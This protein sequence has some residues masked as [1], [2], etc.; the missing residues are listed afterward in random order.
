MARIID[1]AQVLF[2]ADLIRKGKK[3][4]E[5]MV[6][7]SKKWG[8]ISVNTFDRRLASA[9]SIVKREQDELRKETDKKLKEESDHLVNE[10]ISVL[11]RKVIL[12]KIAKGELEAYKCL[13]VRGELQRIKTTPDHTDIMKAIGELNKME[14]E[15]KNE[16]LNVPKS[17]VTTITLPD[18]SVISL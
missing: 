10:I 16:S 7:Y 18:G 9:K 3:R 5:M 6:I 2:L 15:Y 1:S 17:P 14:G 13:S 11:E 12:S 4:S 8:K